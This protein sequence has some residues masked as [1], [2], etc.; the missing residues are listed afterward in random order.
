M[1]GIVLSRRAE[2][3]LR[4]IGAGADLTRVRLALEGLAAGADNLDIKALA[5]NAPWRR[6]RVGDH[7]VL[8]RA[9]VV[10]EA[11]NPNARWLVARIVHRRDLERA[12]S[13]LT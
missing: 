3:D 8:Y 10:G 13:T 11:A 9:I 1:G 4:R 7:R 5:G 2:H 12:V 6:L